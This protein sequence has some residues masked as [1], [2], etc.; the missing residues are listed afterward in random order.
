MSSSY[1]PVQLRAPTDTELAALAV[2]SVVEVHQ[3]QRDDDDANLLDGV[4][5]LLERTFGDLSARRNIIERALTDGTICGLASRAGCTLVPRLPDDSI[6][7][8]AESSSTRRAARGLS[9]EFPAQ[10]EPMLHLLAHGGSESFKWLEDD[11]VSVDTKTGRCECMDCTYHGV[12]SAVMSGGQEDK[13][14]TCKHDQ[15][16]RLCKEALAGDEATI[17]VRDRCTSY[18][19]NYLWRW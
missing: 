9:P 7:R 11:L 5:L 16:R 17:A 6:R 18:L 2:G 19:C 8:H 1:V 15:L 14:G 10:L 13:R 4:I 12:L 3:Q